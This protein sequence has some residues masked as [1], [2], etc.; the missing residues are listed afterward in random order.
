M[1]IMHVNGIYSTRVAFCNCGAVHK[2]RFNQL[3]EAQMLAGTT[4]KPET[5]F[6]FECLDV[7]THIHIL[8]TH[9]FLLL[10]N[11]GHYH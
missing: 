3:L 10:T 5:V 6:T 9:L 2:S 7:M 1:T 11:Y 8:C 4:T